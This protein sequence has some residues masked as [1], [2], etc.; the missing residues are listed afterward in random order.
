MKYVIVGAGPAGITAAETLVKA[1]P[2][3]DVVL[4]GGETHPPYSRMAIPY[5]LTGNIEPE[6]TYLRKIDGH[7][8]GLGIRYVQGVVDHVDP[9]LNT[10][11]LADGSSEPYDKLLVATGS[12]PKTPPVSG[13]GLDGVH[14]CWTLE[15]AAGI[16]ARAQKGSNV[17][18]MGAGFIGCII[19]E[20]LVARGVNLTVIEAEDRMISRM[21]DA[22]GG[23]LLKNWIEAKGV[24]LQTS[25]HVTAIEKKGDGLSVETNKGDA[26][27]ADLVVV[28][29]GVRP[30]VKFLKGSGVTVKDGILVD[31]R[32]QSSVPN[33]YAAG[34]V[35]QGPS[36]G[37]GSSVHA[38]QPTSVD[39]GRLA[40]LNMAGADVAYQGS[41]MM[42]VLDT[43]G[44]VSAS[45]GEWSGEDD[46]A[47]QLNVSQNRY[48]KLAFDGDVLVGALSL[49]RTDHIGV[50]RGLIQSRVAL[51]GWKEKLKKNPS[52]I[53]DAY[54][55]CTQMHAGA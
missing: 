55:A 30:N 19:L 6:G 35:A 33:I 47:V 7:L 13:M 44:L 1:D 50:L 16:A 18:L 38:V 53:A 12:T 32:L 29:V 11:T 2:H 25:T 23:A 31:D 51:G 27:V 15:D 54:V 48:L 20:S 10:L 41:L 49:G 8:D 39:H 4:I 5:V 21:M 28:S 17:V 24:V 36:F 9:K 40:A 46:V 37:G 43:L 22:A 42:N 26:I 34:D 14:H 52:L 3:G 45:F